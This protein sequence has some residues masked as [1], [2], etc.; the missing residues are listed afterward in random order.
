[1]GPLVGDLV[2][3]PF[4]DGLVGVPVHLPDPLVGEDEPVV[5]CPREDPRHLR[6]P[7]GPLLL[8]EEGE[9]PAVR[10]HL[11]LLP[12]AVGILPDMRSPDGHAGVDLSPE[13]LQIVVRHGTLLDLLSPIPFRGG[14]VKVE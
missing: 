9:F 6:G 4:H 3:D 11:P 1:V 7:P 12:D 2:L 5:L 8:R 14:R 13:L 10:R